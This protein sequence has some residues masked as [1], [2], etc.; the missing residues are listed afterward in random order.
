M[1]KESP[2][3]D[4]RPASRPEPLPRHPSRVP[5]ARGMDHG[6]SHPSPRGFIPASRLRANG[7]AVPGLDAAQPEPAQAGQAPH[8]RLCL[9]SARAGSASHQ[10]RR[11]LAV[12]H[13]DQ[14]S[15]RALSLLRRGGE[16]HRSHPKGDLAESWQGS[17]DFRVWT[18]KL[19]KG[20]KW[21]NVAP[22]NGRE[23]VAADIK[24]CYEQYAKEGVQSFTFQEIEGIETP[25][26]YTVRIHL[27]TPNTM[28]PQNLAEPVSIIFAREVLE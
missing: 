1:K 5:E 26:K 19:R 6:G 7:L 16:H 9:G 22:L 17:P 24:Y 28:F 18:F 13:A 15:P 8:A 10:L 11:P 4:P 20:V 21:H 23:L 27:K 25:D 2:D 14:Q 12:R 3:A